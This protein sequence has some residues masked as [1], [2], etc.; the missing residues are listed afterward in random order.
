MTVNKEDVIKSQLS[1]QASY[2]AH[3]QCYLTQLE[4]QIAKTYIA[5]SEADAESFKVLQLRII[6]P[7]RSLSHSDLL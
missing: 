7:S 3:I 1:E 5:V 2:G 6:P 4:Q